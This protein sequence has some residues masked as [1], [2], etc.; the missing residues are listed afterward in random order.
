MIIREIYEPK[1]KNIITGERRRAATVR[2]N[3]RGGEEARAGES[4]GGRG[5]ESEAHDRANQICQDDSSRFGEQHM[6]Q[7]AQRSLNLTLPSLSQP[8]LM[9]TDQNFSESVRVYGVEEDLEHEENFILQ[10]SNLASTTLRPANKA[11]P[12][13]FEKI[14]ELAMAQMTFGNAFINNWTRHGPSSRSERMDFGPYGT[15]FQGEPIF[16]NPF[17]LPPSQ[18][19][20]QSS[21]ALCHFAGGSGQKREGQIM[22]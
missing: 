9:G 15:P 17:G 5:G 19:V 14:T 3:Q 21:S 16:C 13:P 10:K 1:P 4:S 12:T 18:H 2:T 11:G 20:G 8:L 7:S 6:A 22:K